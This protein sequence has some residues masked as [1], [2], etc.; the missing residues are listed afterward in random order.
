[1]AGFSSAALYTHA[2]VCDLLRHGEAGRSRRQTDPAMRR[3]GGNFPCRATGN[4]HQLSCETSV[5]QSG[6]GSDCFYPA[7]KDS[8][9]YRTLHGNDCTGIGASAGAPRVWDR[10][11]RYVGIIVFSCCNKEIELKSKGVYDAS[12]WGVDR[13]GTV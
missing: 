11:R 2:C 1:M 7:Y 3:W 8:A 6:N 5:C 10:L 9:S 13:I 4:A 12:L